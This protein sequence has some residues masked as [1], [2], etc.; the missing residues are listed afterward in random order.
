MGWYEW[1]GARESS[2]SGAR[3]RV[4]RTAR[5]VLRHAMLCLKSFVSYIWVATIGWLELQKVDTIF[6]FSFC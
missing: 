4:Q 1:K 6:L 3:S 5:V 2:G